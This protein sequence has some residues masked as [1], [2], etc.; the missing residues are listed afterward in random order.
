M[1]QLE[2]LVSVAVAGCL[3]RR[4]TEL[5]TV[6][7]LLSGAQWLLDPVSGLAQAELA[8]I[9]TGRVTR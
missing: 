4:S 8:Q 1:Q 3:V 9:C 5:G 2:L 6:Q 7:R